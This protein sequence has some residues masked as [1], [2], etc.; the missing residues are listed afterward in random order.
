MR[1]RFFAA[2]FAAYAIAMFPAAASARP[3][4]KLKLDGYVVTKDAEGHDK[5][6]S[7][8][9]TQVKPGEVIRYVIT[10]T[11]KGDQPALKLMPTD[12]VPAGTAYEPD[13]ASSGNASRVEYSLDAGKTWSLKPTVTVHTPTGNVVKPADPKTYTNVRWFADKALAPNAVV[14]YSYK[15]RVK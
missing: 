1:N 12:K 15:V 13:S 2:L 7:L 5:E 6:T 9:E 3:D 14:T 8:T 10:A 11:N 4:V